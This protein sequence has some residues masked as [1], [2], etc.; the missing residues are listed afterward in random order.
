MA[1]GLCAQRGWSASDGTSTGAAIVSSAS[2][3]TERMR[4]AAD[5]LWERFGD[6]SRGRE[7]SALGEALSWVGFYEIAPD[8]NEHGAEPGSDMILGPHRDTPACSPIGRHGACGQSFFGNEALVVRDVASLGEG[9]VAC[10]PRDLAELVIPLADDSGERWGV[11]DADSFGRGT[12]TEADARL[13][14]A[15]LHAAGLTAASF[16][17]SGL[18]VIG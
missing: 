10:D 8:P 4:L 14:H 18:R 13:M 2:D 11:F 1:G 16:A 5:A 7:R 9:Y 12:F 17:D 3:R 15:F 6:D